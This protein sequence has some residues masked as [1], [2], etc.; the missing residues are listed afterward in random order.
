MRRTGARPSGIPIPQG[1]AAATGVPSTPAAA[2]PGAVSK[3]A[4]SCVASI[5][6]CLVMLLIIGLMM[7]A[8]SADDVRPPRAGSHHHGGR[9][10]HDD[11]PERRVRFYGRWPTLT[12]HA[13]ARALSWM[14]RVL[15]IDPHAL[16]DADEVN[17]APLEVPRSGKPW[18]AVCAH[19]GILDTGAAESD[20]AAVPADAADAAVVAG[21]DAAPKSGVPRPAVDT[22]SIPHALRGLAKRGILCADLD[23]FLS[24]D[25]AAFVGHAG[26]AA[27]ALLGDGTGLLSSEN[28]VALL[29]NLTKEE[30]LRLDASGSLI[31]PLALVAEAVA[32]V[33]AEAPRQAA[34]VS[35]DGLASPLLVTV[36]PKTPV[37]GGGA[38]AMSEM[39]SRVAEDQSCSRVLRQASQKPSHVTVAALQQCGALTSALRSGS[40]ATIMSE[41]GKEF[42][43]AAAAAVS[44]A[45][46]GSAS[47]VTT[48]SPAAPL[49]IGSAV[50]VIIDL[51]AAIFELLCALL[52]GPCAAAHTP[53]NMGDNPIDAYFDKLRPHDRYE[54]EMAL[55]MA[56]ELAASLR[57]NQQQPQSGAGAAHV[58]DLESGL[59]VLPLK[60]RWLQH[61]TAL[62]TRRGRHRA[63]REA[64]TRFG[65]QL[66]ANASMVRAYASAA[67]KRTKAHECSVL[68]T[69]N[70]AYAAT[71]PKTAGHHP[72]LLPTWASHL[73]PSLGYMKQCLAVSPRLFQDRASWTNATVPVETADASGAETIDRRT[74]QCWIADSEYDAREAV[75]KLRCSH[76]VSNKPLHVASRLGLL[77]TSSTPEPTAAATDAAVPSV[78]DAEPENPDTAVTEPPTPTTDAATAAPVDASSS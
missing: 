63:S 5:C 67:A 31:A 26:I 68:A 75:A 71:L 28:G 60:D 44:A 69:V 54:S 20:G 23:V 76:V 38:H 24:R 4:P 52:P 61:R 36:E 27:T 9:G 11:D 7:T 49:R 70:T 41:L 33:H 3:R 46:E 53:G 40:F 47:S 13:T 65:K 45:S 42:A 66:T 30:L 1:G 62:A 73:M 15:D 12:A 21:D 39:A 74:F 72:L 43:N 10:A 51:D 77:P 18:I 19:R 29:G 16:I 57:R 78:P 2:G 25:G 17:A 34:L 56:T 14:S 55:W 8:G 48:G 64:S 37:L 50:R 32:A 35:H 59:F 6:T 22:A 58:T